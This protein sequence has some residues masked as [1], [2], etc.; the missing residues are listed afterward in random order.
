MSSLSVT[1]ALTCMCTTLTISRSNAGS[2][3]NSNTAFTRDRRAIGTR[4]R[5]PVGT[6]LLPSPG[7]RVIEVA[8]EVSRIKVIFI[9]IIRAVGL[10][11]IDISF[12]CCWSRTDERVIAMVTCT[13]GVRLDIAIIAL[14]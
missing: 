9:V 3:C 13:R 2:F 8:K 5:N 14:G 6:C 10:R 12:E 4:L 7:V 1:W 11:A